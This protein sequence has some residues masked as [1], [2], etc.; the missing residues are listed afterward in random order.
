MSVSAS[1]PAPVSA[2]GSGSGP[3]P[4]PGA[5]HHPSITVYRGWNTQGMYVWSPFVVKLEA[6]LRLAGVRYAVAA[7]SPRT[8][9]RGKI[10][11]V[12]LASSSS[13]PEPVEQLS[14]STM[15]IA[16]LS[17][18]GVLPD[19]NAS[20]APAD[21]AHDLALRALLEEKLYFYHG[22][23]R[24]VENYATMRDGV[25]WAIPWPLRL[26]VGVLAR[27]GTEAT[28]RGQGTGRFSGAEVAAFRADIWAAFADLLRAARPAKEEEEG[29]GG[30]F[31]VLGGPAPTEADACLFGFVVSVLVCTAGPDSQAVIRSHPV[32]IEYARRIHDRYFPDYGAPAWT[33]PEVN[34]R[35]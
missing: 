31:W 32:V 7:G 4:G 20:L 29:E 21:R 16:T 6:R 18:R 2:S 25:L 1:T 27:R 14:D 11:Y 19:L 10:P 26:L 13:S 8:A 33:A 34:F 9:P 12:D 3:G 15:I 23:E 24:W 5:A 30:P 28:L 22:R 17:E 35:G